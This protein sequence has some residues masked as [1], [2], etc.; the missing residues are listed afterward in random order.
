MVSGGSATLTHEL[1]RNILL[2]ADAA[3]SSDDYK[4]FSKRQDDIT[5]LGTGT[6]WLINRHL[7]ADLAYSWTHRASS[8]EQQGY[9]DHLLMAKL[10]FRL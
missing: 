7:Y 6:R 4:G 3:Y 10:G 2:E 1:R 9:V 5:S 8:V